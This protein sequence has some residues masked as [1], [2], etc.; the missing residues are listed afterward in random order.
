LVYWTG[1]RVV[2]LDGHHRREAYRRAKVADAVPVEWFVGGLDAAIAEAGA[3]NCQDK[4]RMTTPE[5]MNFA[6]RLVTL[7]KLSKADV[8]RASG[9]GDGQIALMKRVKKELEKEEPGAAERYRT[10]RQAQDAVKGR[11]GWTGMDE[12]ELKDRMAAQAKEWTRRM[13]QAVGTKLAD[14]PEIAAMALAGLLG[15][16]LPDVVSFLLREHITEDQRDEWRMEDDF[17]SDF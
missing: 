9:A 3:R 1:A 12:D 16:K 17:H 14:S 8:R 2:L 10:W 5:R 15:R 11:E 6:W 4:L 13:G 7:T